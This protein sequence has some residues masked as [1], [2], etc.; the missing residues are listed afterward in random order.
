MS[1]GGSYAAR[2]AA[3]VAGSRGAVDVDFAALGA[4]FWL[5]ASRAASYVASGADIT[6][7]K[8]LISGT[9]LNTKVGGAGTL[10]IITD[11]RDGQPAFA[12]PTGTGWI[13]GVDA[14]YIA[15]V[16]GTD[17]PFCSIA[18]FELG[19]A[20]GAYCLD[21][22]RN[23]GNSGNGPFFLSSSGD[24]YFERDG[25][26]SGPARTATSE[27]IP[28]GLC[29]VVQ[30]SS[31][32]LTVR[33]SING[34]PETIAA[35]FASAGA[36]S[37]NIVGIGCRTGSADTLGFYGVQRER[38]FFGANRT[39]AEYSPLVAALMRKWPLTTAPCGYFAGDSI[40]AAVA[41]GVTN[42]GMQ[43]LLTQR[44]RALGLYF[45]PI[46]PLST[47]GG[48]FPYCHSGASGNTCAQINTRVQD[49]IQGLGQVGGS[50]FS[51]ATPT[52]SRGHYRRA[53]RGFLLAG[54]NDLST[55]NYATLL[56]N[57]YAQGV[58]AYAGFKIYVTTIP[59]VTGATAA[60]TTFNNSLKDPGG[61][62]DTHEATYPG[63]LIRWDAFGTGPTRPDGTH[64]DNAG[65]VAMIDHPTKGLLQA[66]IAD[67]ASIQ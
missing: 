42:G 2:M 11:P 67:I 29:V 44:L 52:P 28:A 33:T 31:D 27:K 64:P 17:K 48:M 9:S 21:S 45:D 22:V 34:A 46:G 58:Q 8:S 53:K 49:Y 25:A 39:F 12:Y 62:W 14:P 10:Q 40:T 20:S 23:S 35:P 18:V 47:G 54:T 6:E 32:G 59:D 15:A 36:I 1:F 57:M 5:D 4:D 43:A 50:A 51:G 7:F 30:A 19:L 66:A 61:V 24:W 56:S 65:Y 37:A 60:V 26:P 63:T 13:K 41:S 55:P 16:N 3:A 38:A